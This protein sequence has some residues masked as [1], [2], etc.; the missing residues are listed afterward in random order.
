MTVPAV[1][2][3]WLCT[4]CGMTNRKLVPAD[5]AGA[6]DRCQH[7]RARHDISPGTRPTR[8]MAELDD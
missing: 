7:C 1:T 8:W 4:R 6:E 2:A 3:E 5:A